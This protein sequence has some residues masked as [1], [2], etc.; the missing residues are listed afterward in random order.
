VTGKST[1]P[2]PEP[3]VQLQRQL[4]QFRSTPAAADVDRCEG[5]QLRVGAA[6][7]ARWISLDG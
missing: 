6:S 4:D 2:I 3:I 1:S 5:A 7:A